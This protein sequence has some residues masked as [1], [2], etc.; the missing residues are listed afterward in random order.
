VKRR[1]ARELIQVP[2]TADPSG[3]AVRSQVWADARTWDDFVQAASDGTIMHSWAWKD[4]IERSCGHRAPFLAAVEGSELRG[5]LPL[6]VI[7]SRMLGR[8]VVSLPF[9]D[10]AGMCTSG[11]RRAEAVLLQAAKDMADDE[12]AVLEVRQF[13]ERDL[14]LARSLEKVTMQIDIGD[15]AEALW[16][17]LPSNR[18]GQVRKAQRNG[19]SSSI[20][21]TEAIHE[22]YRVLS[23]NMRD[24]GSPEHGVTFF[25]LLMDA[26]GERARIILVRTSA[27]ET[28][29]GGIMLR[30]RDRVSLPWSSSLRSSFRLGPNQILYWEAMCHAIAWGAS[31]F[32][33]GRSSRD[34]G[35]FESKREWGTEPAQLAWYHYP[36][37]AAAS[38]QDVQRFAWVTKVWQH[39]PVPVANAIGPRIRKSIP[40]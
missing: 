32:D 40:N 5:V 4:V 20:H 21:G 37:T 34:S 23:T 39:L 2:D 12:R 29:G 11:D 3:S 30:D 8:R 26:L 14:N 31:V 35:T 22:F 18:R 7:R 6:V 25:R 27:G 10:H 36:E 13:G 17:R 1:T 9:L 38:Y 19:L 24:L 16:K 33:F 15:G 28:I